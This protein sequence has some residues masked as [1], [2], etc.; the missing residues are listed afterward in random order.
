MAS[1]LI[2][3]DDES[4]RSLLAQ[5]MTHAGHTVR[6]AADGNKGLALYRAEPSDIVL[7]DLVMPEKE[8][9]ATIMELRREYPQVRIIAM[10]GGFA[11]DSRV[12]LHMAERLGAV[13]VLRKPFSLAELETVIA[14]VHAGRGPVAKTPPPA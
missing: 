1:L 8:G 2:I 11:H 5:A 6:E 4:I 13:R 14:E 12:Y 9:L 7:T 10:S 3:D